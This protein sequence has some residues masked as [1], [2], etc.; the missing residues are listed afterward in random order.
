MDEILASIRRIISDDEDDAEQKDLTAQTGA[1]A[2]E[3]EALSQSAE[4]AEAAGG[5]IDDDILELT[6]ELGQT[7]FGGQPE[8]E[9]PG[10]VVEPEQAAADLGATGGEAAGIGSFEPMAET[11]AGEIEMMEEPGSGGESQGE[12]LAAAPEGAAMAESTPAE[13]VWSGF[14][15][16]EESPGTGA[17]FNST[18]SDAVGSAADE[19]VAA[20]EPAGPVETEPAPSAWARSLGGGTAAEASSGGAEAVASGTPDLPETPGIIAEA[21]GA[22]VRSRAAREGESAP[23]RPEELKEPE[24]PEELVEEETAEPVAEAGEA[25]GEETFEMSMDDIIEARESVL[26]AG[27]EETVLE[28]P[29]EEE[30]GEEAAPPKQAGTGNGGVSGKSFEASVKEMLR[31]MLRAWLDENLPRILESAVKEELGPRSKSE[32]H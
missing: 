27:E 25:E 4:T 30:V 10:A 29:S 9:V 18:L 5:T 24:E 26:F 31:P 12:P 16:D 14:D 23:E 6:N 20:G 3:P 7:A 32:R 2:P 17:E 22:I 11:G 8:V 1:A 28:E 13:V 19:P 15:E 21:V